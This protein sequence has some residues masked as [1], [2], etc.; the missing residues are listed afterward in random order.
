MS[1]SS[2]FRLKTSKATL[3]DPVVE[4]KNGFIFKTI[5]LPRHENGWI[6]KKSDLFFTEDKKY[7]SIFNSITK[8]ITTLSATTSES[9]ISILPL[10][11]DICLIITDQRVYSLNLANDQINYFD[12]SLPEISPFT[13]PLHWVQTLR[14]KYVVA[15]Y[16]TGAGNI[17]Y[18]FDIQEKSITASNLIR[19]ERY[20]SHHGIKDDYHV[21]LTASG[22]LHFISLPQIKMKDSPLMVTAYQNESKLVAPDGFHITYNGDFVAICVRNDEDLDVNL[23]E[24]LKT[25]KLRFIAKLSRIYDC[26]GFAANN[27]FLYIQRTQS[28]SEKF[29]SLI[30]DIVYTRYNLNRPRHPTIEETGYLHNRF[31]EKRQTQISKSK[32]R[33]VVP[34]LAFC[35]P[36]FRRILQCM[37]PEQNTIQIVTSD[38]CEEILTAS[39]VEAQLNALKPFDTFPRGITGLVGNYLTLLPPPP[40]PMPVGLVSFIPVKKHRRFW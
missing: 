2:R 27:D 15:S 18:L 39:E 3:P 13:L 32:Q 10:S 7:I 1:L 12:V 33:E 30:A 9:F 23:Y 5:S 40:A 6:T 36:Y 14:N 26:S 28:Y 17:I 16:Y 31:V 29:K 37:D 8:K 24:V 25:F 4:T 35:D 21:F 20:I 11:A 19:G 22:H 38:C 34:Y